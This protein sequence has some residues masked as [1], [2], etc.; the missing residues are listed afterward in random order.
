MAQIQ[1]A[2]VVVEMKAADK[3]VHL[4]DNIV[5]KSIV[6]EKPLQILDCFLVY[7]NEEPNYL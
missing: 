1:R 7:S 4:L 5:R 2:E 3:F 6:K